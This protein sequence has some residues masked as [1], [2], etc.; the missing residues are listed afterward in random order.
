MPNRSNE[1]QPGI[2]YPGHFRPSH[3]VVALRPFFP[4]ETLTTCA[5]TSVLL[6]THGVT[7]RERLAGFFTRALWAQ[8]PPPAPH[9]APAPSA[10]PPGSAMLSSQAEA[11]SPGLQGPGA[12]GAAQ[13]TP[14]GGAPPLAAGDGASPNAAAE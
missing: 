2:F 14:A 4:N 5:L 3:A 9:S 10:A 7:L 13:G 1:T 6:R 8:R 12:E 11:A